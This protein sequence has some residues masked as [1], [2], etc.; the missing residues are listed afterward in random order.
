MLRTVIIF[1]LLAIV[2]YDLRFH[3]ITNRALTFLAFLLLQDLHLASL[4][5]IALSELL[6]AFLSLGLRFGGG[7]FK[8]LSLL[9]I[10]EGRLLISIEYLHWFF[11][12]IILSLLMKCA[13]TGSGRGSLA[14]APSILAPFLILYLAI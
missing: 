4:Q 1:T 13:I 8:L 12:A 11:A 9:T 3:L 10:T 5:S 7:D 14:M 2:I 6:I